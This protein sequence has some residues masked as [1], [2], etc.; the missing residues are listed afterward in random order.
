LSTDSVGPDLQRRV[1]AAADQLEDLGHELDLADA[2]G[3]ELDVIGHVLARD[4]AADLRVQVA[5]GVDGAE[6]EVLAEDEGARNLAQRLHPLADCRA[7]GIRAGVHDA[8]LDPGV[9]FPFAALGD[10]VVFQR[11]ERADQRPGVAVRAQAHVD[12]EHLAVG[13]Q[14]AERLDHALAEAGEEIVVFDRFRP[15]GLAFFGID[16]DVIDV[17]GDVQFA[18]AQLAHADDQQALRL[19]GAVERFAVGGASWRW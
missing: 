6:V 10:E 19:A 4:F 12:A 15:G 2:A 8:R 16:E 18:P 11:V 1:A 3:A 5:H 17:R 7:V 13:G 9:A 14:V